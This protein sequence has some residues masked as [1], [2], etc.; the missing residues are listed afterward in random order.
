M[1]SS[2]ARQYLEG[3]SSP[4]VKA[5][6]EYVAVRLPENEAAFSLLAS[7]D[8]KLN[9]IPSREFTPTEL[10]YQL[11]D[12][13]S[14]IRSI[15]RDDAGL[16]ELAMKVVWRLQP[17]KD[18]GTKQELFSGA[19]IIDSGVAA[20]TDKP[21]PA[22]TKTTATTSAE[23]KPFDYK[24]LIVPGLILLG[25]AL[26]KN[27]FFDGIMQRLKNFGIGASVEDEVPETIDEDP[28]GDG[29]EIEDE[30]DDEPV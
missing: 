15:I 23:P 8:K 11:N 13:K 22:A 17:V 20:G 5:I 18:T 26:W 19:T 2:A 21:D 29:E 30:D 25:I 27:G 1:A 12:Y 16:A 3:Q 7:I 24:P 10:D 14:K 28:F 4:E 6:Y 9:G